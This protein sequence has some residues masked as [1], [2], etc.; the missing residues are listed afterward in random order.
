MRKR[1]TS[2][3]VKNYK[4]YAVKVIKEKYIRQDSH[5]HPLWVPYESFPRPI[6]E[7]FLD[8]CCLPA[9]LAI[10]PMLKKTFPNS[11]IVVGS[12]GELDEAEFTKLSLC[13]KGVEPF[14]N[15]YV[16]ENY[17]AWIKLDA[18]NPNSDI[19]DITSILAKNSPQG[20]IDQRLKNSHFEILDNTSDVYDFHAKYVL[21]K[22]GLEHACKY[23]KAFAAQQ[24]VS[25][26]V[27]LG[28]INSKSSKSLKRNPKSWCDT[29]RSLF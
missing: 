10:L 12:L 25:E 6:S 21:Y 4:S 19:L 8:S 9:H 27:A 17:H 11:S 24:G 18:T 14:V 28:T 20:Y 2:G 22:L 7:N 1:L 3:L 29:L 15:N 13:I 16:Y 23:L 5:K 26:D